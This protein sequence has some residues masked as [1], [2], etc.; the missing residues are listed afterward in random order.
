MAKKI[1][2]TSTLVT[3]LSSKGA[4]T[5]VEY[6]LDGVLQRKYV[7]TEK[8]LNQFVPDE[9]LAR[10]IQYGFPWE[11]IVINFDMQQFATE[12]HNAELWTVEDVLKSPKK[13]TGVLRKIFEDSFKAVLETAVRE[14]KR[15]N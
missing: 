15:S 14:K 6:M 10:G 3:I 4:S 8:V 13:L 7:P 5:L 2:G 11:E 12:M 1:Q 9:V